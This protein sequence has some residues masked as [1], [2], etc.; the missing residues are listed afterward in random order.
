MQFELHVPP[1]PSWEADRGTMN[2]G[3][4]TKNPGMWCDEH[5]GAAPGNGQQPGGWAG[6]VP[7]TNG[8]CAGRGRRTGWPLESASQPNWN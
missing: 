5:V 1:R 4:I 3:L 8:N 6:V 2:N 7:N